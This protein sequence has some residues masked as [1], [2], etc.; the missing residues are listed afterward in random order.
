MKARPP[1]LKSCT[2]ELSDSGFENPVYLTLV[3]DTDNAGRRI[4]R[5]IFLNGLPVEVYDWG[6]AVTRFI[7]AVFRREEN[8]DF[9]ATEM[10]E[11][12]SIQGGYHKNGKHYRSIMA[13]I[14]EVLS[15]HLEVLKGENNARY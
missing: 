5:E 15:K 9:V 13:E 4:P 6:T 14:G 10:Q 11:I 7:S 1:E 3:E 12:F 8:V 2:W